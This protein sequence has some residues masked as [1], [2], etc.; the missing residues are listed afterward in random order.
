MYST[1]S[2]NM[3]TVSVLLH[4]CSLSDDTS[5][6]MAAAEMSKDLSW[7][8]AQADHGLLGLSSQISYHCDP[9]LGLPLGDWPKN[10]HQMYGP[11][12]HGVACDMAY[13]AL[14]G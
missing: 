11:M 3:T 7:I 2:D 6:L 12:I 14:K 9:V 5:E 1:L 8:I 10:Q 4:V 13:V